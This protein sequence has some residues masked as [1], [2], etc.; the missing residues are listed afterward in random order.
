MRLD[1]LLRDRFLSLRSNGLL[2]ARFMAL[3]EKEIR[4]EPFLDK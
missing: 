1:P 2:F 3:P 4:R